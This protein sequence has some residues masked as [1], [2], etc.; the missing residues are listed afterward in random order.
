M[1]RRSPRSFFG[2]L[3]NATEGEDLQ[4][5]KIVEGSE[6]FEAWWKLPHRRAPCSMAVR[7]VGL[8]SRSPNISDLTK[9]A[10]EIWK[11]EDHQRTLAREFWVTFA[12]TVNVDILLER[13]PKQDFV[14]HTLGNEVKCEW[15]V[16]RVRTF[17]A[18]EVATMSG[19]GP[20][21][22]SVGYAQ[23]EFC[24]TWGEEEELGEQ[25]VGGVSMNTQ[26][27]ACQRF[28]HVG[29]N[30][31]MAAANSKGAPK[32]RRCPHATSSSRGT[33]SAG[34]HTETTSSSWGTRGT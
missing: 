33:R 23:V 19:S 20:V 31:P 4:A 3:V 30:C 21:P 11:R 2:L 32:G 8:D 24:G 6:G 34:S 18:D 22:I 10:T 16:K 27:H 1:W 15:T 26:C 5:V 29:R 12:G 7:L 13:L 9:V 28:G 14:F 25:G 17:V